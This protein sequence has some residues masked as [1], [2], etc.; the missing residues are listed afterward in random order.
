MSIL[1][2]L[3]LPT[4]VLLIAALCGSGAV[5]AQTSPDPG[6]VVDQDLPVPA[7]PTTPD[8]EAPPSKFQQLMTDAK[9]YFTAPLRWS[10]AQWGLFAGALA[11]IGGAHSVDSQVRTHFVDQYPP[12]HNF[13]SDDVQDA[14]PGAA[15]L[16]ATMGYASWTND[17]DGRREAWTMQ[18][19]LILSTL[20]IYPMKYIVR[21]EGP[22]QTSNANEW[23]KGGGGS[24]PSEHTAAAFA[25]GTV[26]AES[27][28]DDYRWVRRF[29]GYGVGVGT[30]FLRLKHNQHWLSDTVAGA[31]IGA[32]SADFHMHRNY[33]SDDN[34]QLSLV[35]V[36]GGVMLT[37]QLTLQ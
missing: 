9:L 16:L 7:P 26:L 19:S 3:K 31:A 32:A 6:G 30:A 22:D 2:K 8:N 36:A 15:V 18:E 37:Y 1:P 27:G 29:I 12:G 28:N 35:P 24:F 33:R 14:I 11:A 17:E 20:T 34:S 10:P 25:I 21:R 5:W 13:K 23:F 4:I